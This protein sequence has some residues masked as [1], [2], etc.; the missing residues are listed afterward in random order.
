MFL[1]KK[2][3]KSAK[4]KRKLIKIA[5]YYSPHEHSNLW[6]MTSDLWP[7]REPF[8]LLVIIINTS[9]LLGNWTRTGYQVVFITGKLT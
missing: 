6:G 5:K 9:F 8:M 3:E 4:R 2:K 1:T 7:K